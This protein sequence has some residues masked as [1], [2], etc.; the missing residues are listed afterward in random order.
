MA[1]KNVTKKQTFYYDQLDSLTAG[2]TCSTG[3]SKT[4]LK[5]YDE[6]FWE[7]NTDY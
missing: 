2:K 4:L 6:A 5:I 1:W 3:V 7:N